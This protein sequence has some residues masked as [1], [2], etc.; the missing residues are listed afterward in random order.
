MSKLRFLYVAIIG[1]HD[2]L[3]SGEEIFRRMYGELNF[4]FVYGSVKFVVFNNNVSVVFYEYIT[5][6]KNLR[7]CNK[8]LKFSDILIFLW[9]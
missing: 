7:F 3:E 6:F 9:V 8:Y 5:R 1:N 2:H 4:S